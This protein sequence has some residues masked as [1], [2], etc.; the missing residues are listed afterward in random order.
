M[1]AFDTDRIFTAALLLC[2]HE[3]KASAS[4]FSSA[5][6]EKTKP[7]GHMHSILL[8]TAW[9]EEGLWEGL[10]IRVREW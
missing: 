10:L 7:A 4:M 8:W 1:L 6:P 5:M 2:P 9:K 3:M